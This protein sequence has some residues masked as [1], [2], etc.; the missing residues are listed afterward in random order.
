MA[1]QNQIVIFGEVFERQPQFAQAGH[2]QEMGVVDDGG[3]HHTEVVET[4]RLFDEPLFAGEVAPV[5]FE[6][7]GLAQ[8]AQSVAVSVEGAGDGGCDEPFG[9]MIL[10]GLFDDR[11][12]GAGLA[13]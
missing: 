12:A 2:L 5:D 6:T 8:D 4:E 9:I 7:E 3:D 11:F 10:E 1:D 13:Q